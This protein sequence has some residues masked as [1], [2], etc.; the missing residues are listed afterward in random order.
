MHA[1]RVE[2]VLSGVLLSLGDMEHVRVLVDAVD[3]CLICG[4]VVT[5]YERCDG[6]P[7]VEGWTEEHRECTRGCE[8]IVSPAVSGRRRSAVA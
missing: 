8:V 5:V 4:A 6:D 1:R 7:D 2:A 3:P